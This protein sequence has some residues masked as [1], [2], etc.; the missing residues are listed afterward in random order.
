MN[1]RNIL[2]D[3][4]R[5]QLDAALQAGDRECA[6][7]ILRDLVALGAADVRDPARDL[8]DALIDIGSVFKL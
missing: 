5:E 3:L 7:E 6:A 1:A 8:R 4:Y 2:R